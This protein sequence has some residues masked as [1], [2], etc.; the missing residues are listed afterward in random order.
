MER[1]DRVLKLHRLMVG[2]RHG[3]TFD[4][5]Q[6]ELGWSRSTLRR[7]L[8]Y[9]KDGLQAPLVH[10]RLR[11]FRYEG[12]HVYE[13]PG[14]WFSADELSALLVLDALL[15]RHP[16]GMLSE[17]LRPARQRIEKLLHKAGTGIPEWTRRLRM[18]RSASRP[19][20]THFTAVAGALAQRKRLRIDYHARSDD[21]MMPRLI[22]PQRLTFYRDNWYLDAWCHRRDALRI[23][24]LDRIIAVEAMEEAAV[25]VPDAQ[26]DRT[27]ATSYGIF[28][29]EPSATATL[30]FT[31]QAARWVAHEIWHPDQQDTR[32]EDGSLTRQLPYHRNEE[33]LMDLMRHG[34][35]VEVVE[36]EGLRKELTKRL[37]EALTRYLNPSAKPMEDRDSLGPGN[38]PGTAYGADM[39]HVRA[40]QL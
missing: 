19:A 37:S 1:L 7:T 5:L 26:L 32:H 6:T 22:S 13:L 27:L 38:E 16:L 31:P 11:G 21:R 18:L 28:A 35:D 3:I 20:G 30:R 2:R 33:L 24:A 4:D 17:A 39:A 23:F 36:P 34:A 12:E 40:H 8:N 15:E 25:D 10:D 29:G 14:L 9:L